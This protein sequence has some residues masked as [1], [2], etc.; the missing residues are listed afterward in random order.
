[1]N[2]KRIAAAIIACGIFSAIIF[3]YLLIHNPSTYNETDGR[4][5]VSL[6]NYMVDKSSDILAM[7]ICGNS[8]DIIYPELMYAEFIP[9]EAGTWLV[10]TTLLDDSEGPYNLSIYEEEFYASVSEVEAINQALYGGLEYTTESQV[11]IYN[12][13]DLGIMGFGLDILYNDGTW[14]QLLTIQSGVGYM[15]LLE[16]TYQSIPDTANPFGHDLGR[17][18]NLLNGAVLEPG[19]A[20]DSLIL[21]MNQVFTD[22]LDN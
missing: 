10:R 3:S 13:T 14:I 19:S 17:D 20:L 15:I 21:Q 22:H 5:G 16:G 1:M 9:Q 2:T 6:A 7:A 4:F 8:S 11:S 18:L 12:V